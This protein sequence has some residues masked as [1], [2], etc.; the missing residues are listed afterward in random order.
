L[1]LWTY[2]ILS[3]KLN[4]KLLPTDTYIHFG[5]T[6]KLFASIAQYRQRLLEEAQNNGYPV[7]RHPV[8]LHSDDKKARAITFQQY[9]LGDSLLIAPVLS[10]S[11]TY[12]K[13]YFPLIE[14][15]TWR[16]IWTGKYYQANGSK[17]AVDA[18]LGQ[19]PVFVKEPREDDGLLNDL[20]TYA[21]SYY[22]KSPK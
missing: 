5:H 10:P 7:M 17:V 11:T 9:Y 15:V 3:L 22:E 14:G 20:L 19:P 8:L 1:T 4:T 18:P 21:A 12:V 16:H 13:V 2:P 6:A